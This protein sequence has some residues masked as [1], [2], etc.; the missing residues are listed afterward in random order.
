MGWSSR[1]TNE[2]PWRFPFNGK[3]TIA[4][5]RPRIWLHRSGCGCHRSA[6]RRDGSVSPWPWQLGPVD[7]A[8]ECSASCGAMRGKEPV[9]LESVVEYTKETW[10]G[11]GIV[12]LMLIDMYS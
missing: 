9:K 8:K 1:K 10:I 11:D 2:R 12:L 3:S 5:S 6:A 4:D 7:V